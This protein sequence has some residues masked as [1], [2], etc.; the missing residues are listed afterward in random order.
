MVNVATISICILAVLVIIAEFYKSTFERKMESQD[1]RGQML[2]F[3][4][5]SILILF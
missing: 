2:I 4:I 3:K 5:K 1:E